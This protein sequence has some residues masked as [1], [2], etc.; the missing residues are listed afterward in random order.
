M[1]SAAASVTPDTVRPTN[2]LGV[3]EVWAVVVVE[4]KCTRVS[5]ERL[6]VPRNG[7]KTPLE[8]PRLGS[9]D[10]GGQATQRASNQITPENPVE[11]SAD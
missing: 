11:M 6:K 5:T 2:C 9:E 4:Q 7:V 1:V 8:E 3:E 10:R